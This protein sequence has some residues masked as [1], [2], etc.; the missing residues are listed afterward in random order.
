MPDLKKK[1]KKARED[2]ITQLWKNRN[3]LPK[4]FPISGDIV[5]SPLSIY[6]DQ[7]A[8]CLHIGKDTLATGKTET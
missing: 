4:A 6:L 1:K 8:G 2:K 7:R 3:L 5:I